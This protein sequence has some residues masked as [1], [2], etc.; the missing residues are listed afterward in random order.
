MVRF[1]RSWPHEH[2]GLDYGFVDISRFEGDLREI[3]HRQS[4]TLPLKT[5]FSLGMR[6]IDVL[7]YVPSYEY[8]HARANTKAP[9][10]LLG[11]G[12]G[13]ENKL[14]PECVDDDESP[15]DSTEDS[16]DSKGQALCFP[17][18]SISNE[19]VE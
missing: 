4:K 16:M 2:Q 17:H 10:L 7:E 9:T 14:G 15:F 19:S 1:R 5:V 6:G 12:K 8:I 11:F 18:S 13:N 3:F